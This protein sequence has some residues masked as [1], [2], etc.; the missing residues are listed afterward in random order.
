ML[1]RVNYSKFEGFTYFDDS[2]HRTTRNLQ[3]E[4]WGEYLVAWRKDSLEI[5]RDH[6]SSKVEFCLCV[7]NS[8]LHL[9]HFSVRH[10]KNGQLDTKILPMSFH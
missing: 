3:F 1:V 4:D 2:V 9:L 6:V 7:L 5:Y 8:W 10:A